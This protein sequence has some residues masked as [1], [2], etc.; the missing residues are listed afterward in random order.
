RAGAAEA[1]RPERVAGRRGED[2]RHHGHRRRDDEAVDQ[3]V[4]EAAERPRAAERVEAQVVRDREAGDE[5]ALLVEGEQDDREDRVDRDYR[6]EHED[7]VAE[8][9]LAARDGHRAGSRSTTFVITNATA[10][11]ISVSTTATAAARPTFPL[12]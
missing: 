10:K 8:D 9:L 3:A 5:V 11:M 12:P 7:P 2:R 1:H 4:V 6:E